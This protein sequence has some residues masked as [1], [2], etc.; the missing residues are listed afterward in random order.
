MAEG[1]DDAK[2]VYDFEYVDIDGEKQSMSRYKDHVLIVVNVASKWGKTP[3]NYRELTELHNKYG[4]SNGLRVLGFPCNQ[5]GGQEPGTE[6]DIKKFAEGYGVKWDLSSKIDVNGDHTHPLWKYMKSK[7]S[8]MLGK[9]IKWNFTKFLIGPDGQVVERYGPQ[10][11]PVEMESD[12][13][14][15]FAL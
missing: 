12:L 10:V 4:E 13:N 7:K 2:S 15:L 8:G 6:A 14:K 3:V 5:F 11:N 9:F 1:G